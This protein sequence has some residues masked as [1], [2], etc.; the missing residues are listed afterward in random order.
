MIVRPDA[1]QNYTSAQTRSTTSRNGTALPQE[2]SPH[3][4]DRTR[5]NPPHSDEAS[6]NDMSSNIPHNIA[7]FPGLPMLPGMAGVVGG[8][9]MTAMQIHL[10]G[11]IPA[12]FMPDFNPYL[13]HHQAM[14]A[15]H[16][17]MAAQESQSG[18]T[19]TP[20]HLSSSVTAT[21][22]PPLQTTPGFPIR[23]PL[24]TN[25]Q[26]Q[27]TRLAYELAHRQAM[28]AH[29]AAI[30]GQWR[31]GT[32]TQFST[33]HNNLQP[34]AT[35]NNSDIHSST[36]AQAS[37]VLPPS[38]T[39]PMGQPRQIHNAVSGQPAIMSVSHPVGL[40]Q[41]SVLNP[42][43]SERLS[44][45]L[46]GLY[47][48]AQLLN[49]PATMYLLSSTTGPEAILHHNQ[50]A[51]RARFTDSSE[52]RRDGGLQGGSSTSLPQVRSP[53]N[54]AITN[55]PQHEPAQTS[56][57][58]SSTA[59]EAP[60][61]PAAVPA[62]PPIV[63]NNANPQ[64]N[65]QH[66]NNR[67]IDLLAP[68]QPVL[69]HL[70]L[71]V[72]VSIFVF[73]FFGLDRGYRR[74]LLAMLIFSVFILLRSLETRFHVMNG[75]RT[76]WDDIIG[77]RQPQ[78]HEANTHDR[79]VRQ[80]DGGQA[81]LSNTQDTLRTG[82]QAVN[83]IPHRDTR[84]ANIRERL[85]PAE[86]ALA[87]FFA[88]LVPG[89]GENALRERRREE[90]ERQEREAQARRI[91][92]EAAHQIQDVTTLTDDQ[93]TS[94][95]SANTPTGSIINNEDANLKTSATATGVDLNGLNTNS[96]GES[97][98]ENRGGQGNHRTAPNATTAS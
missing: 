42:P 81:L 53:S 97:S 17:A 30:T 48:H 8:P 54:I 15:Q 62:Q 31:S 19:A 73:L 7:Q 61:A 52:S 66:I 68:L 84:L 87:L 76:W 10:Q 92:E 91:A 26:Q 23:G 33:S 14:A 34:N 86:R 20:S 75:I 59:R 27:Q 37:T 25:H 50:V 28:D 5:S 95:G 24:F 80:P 58:R 77:I 74:P 11:H 1:L 65:Q 13:A 41:P 2:T 79:A 71:L 4:N 36:H 93:L 72:R 63:Q 46:A 98:L 94:S 40:P 47:G 38:I 32:G 22:P 70:W 57:R 43:E 29:N 55:V 90:H 56:I 44:Q 89:L 49:F 18:E 83:I 21:S 64:L 67:D 82:S 85:R 6:S 16:Q 12:P 35:L 9:G 45:Q 51:Y 3:R 69:R 60:P 88:S 39:L 78:I 96:H